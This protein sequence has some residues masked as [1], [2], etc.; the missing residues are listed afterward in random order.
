MNREERKFWPYSIFV[1][2]IL[3][4]LMFVGCGVRCDAVSLKIISRLEWGALEPNI[5]G[6]VEGEYD[7]LENPGGWFVYQRPLAEVYTTIVVHHSALPLSDGALD[8]QHKHTNIKGYADIGYH[9]V[10]DENGN[11]Y[12]GRELMVRGAHTG[13]HN[14]GAIGV[15]LLGNFDET[16]PTEA[17]IRSLRHLS[18]CLI[19]KY[20]ITHIAG[21]RDFQ[22]DD[23]VCPGEHLGEELLVKLAKK[24]KIVFGTNTFAKKR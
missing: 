13:G 9:Y 21:H 16:E 22:P 8:I 5:Q 2:V 23:T 14:T 10:I 19:D 20:Q 12:E 1:Y 17:Q 24:L 4:S 18:Q 15:V 7:V 11:I 3:F 6:S